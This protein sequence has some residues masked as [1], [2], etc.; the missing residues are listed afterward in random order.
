MLPT[1]FIP[2]TLLEVITDPFEI[3][4]RITTFQ[5]IG[6]LGVGEEVLFEI[7]DSADAD[8]W[9]T[10]ELNDAEVKITP[11]NDQVTF[12]APA[13]VRIRKTVTAAVVGLRVLTPLS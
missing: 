7:E 9:R 3:S 5:I 10:M 12:Y 6:T 13:Y 8:G 11:G 2:E 4:A 1:A